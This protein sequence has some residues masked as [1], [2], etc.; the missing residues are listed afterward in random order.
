VGASNS[1]QI[2]TTIAWDFA[3]ILI[4]VYSKVLNVNVLL[5]CFGSLLQGSPAGKTQNV[6][7]FPRHPC[8]FPY[9]GSLFV[10]YC[11]AIFKAESVNVKVLRNFAVIPE[12]VV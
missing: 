1:P 12:V 2:V 3:V 10:H 9:F 11:I 7:I 4:A 8:C 6:H 5:I